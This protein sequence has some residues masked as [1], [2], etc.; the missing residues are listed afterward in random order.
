MTAGFGIAAC[1][2]TEPPAPA[3]TAHMRVTQAP[4]AGAVAAIV[5]DALSSAGTEKRTLVVYVGADWCEPCQKFHR[6][7]ESGELDTV[8]PSLTILEFDLDRD[9]KRLAAAGYVSRYVPLFA[10]PKQDGTASG[11]QIE[12]VTKGEGVV[13][14]IAPRLKELLAQ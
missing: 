9:A 14:Y 8:F 5:R 3:V 2:R 4:A 1:S 13:A 11:K 6:A 10:L 7:A 12:G